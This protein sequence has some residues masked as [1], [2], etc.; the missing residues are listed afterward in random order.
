MELHACEWPFFR[1]DE[2]E[3]FSVFFINN[4]SKQL[5]SIKFMGPLKEKSEIFHIIF[6]NMLFLSH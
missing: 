5:F 1:G 2:E 3:T 6:L 4:K